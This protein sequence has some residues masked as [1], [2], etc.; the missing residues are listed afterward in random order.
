MRYAL[1]KSDSMSVLVTLYFL[2]L[3]ENMQWSTELVLA[4]YKQLS[5]M[6]ELE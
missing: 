3:L 6:I 2:F 1:A 5:N 4:I